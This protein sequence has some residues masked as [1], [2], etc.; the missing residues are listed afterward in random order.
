M[1]SQPQGNIM[2]LLREGLQHDPV[3]KSLIALA[4][5]GKTKRFWVEDGLLYTKGRRLYVPKWG[6]IRRNLIKECHDTKWV[7][8][9]G[10]DARGHYSS[11]LTIGLKYGMR[12][13]PT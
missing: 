10:N 6:N 11:R 8:T 4:H 2:D 7:G 9:Q 13:R 1:T 12:L 5:E 3:A